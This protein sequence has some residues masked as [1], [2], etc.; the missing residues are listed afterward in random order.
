[1]EIRAVD[2]QILLCRQMDADYRLPWSL[3][4]SSGASKF[5]RSVPGARWSKFITSNF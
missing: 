3:T 2:I 4:R 5:W 1:M